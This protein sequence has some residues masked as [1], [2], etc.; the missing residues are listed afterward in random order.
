[1]SIED[2]YKGLE[3]SLDI[4]LS[5]RR[6]SELMKGGMAF[7]SQESLNESSLNTGLIRSQ[8]L[9]SAPDSYGVKN[10]VRHKFGKHGQ[11]QKSFG[12]H[13]DF[14]DIN[15]TDELRYGYSVTLFMDIIGSTK[16]GVIYTPEEVFGIKNDIIRCAI[17]TIDSFDGHVHR[18]MG[19]AVMAFFRSERKKADGLI[20]D[21]GI[22]ALN[23][24]AF[25]IEMMEKVVS[26]KLS[27]IGAEKIGIRIGI[28][29]GK[30]ED[31]I[32]GTYGYLGSHEVTATSYHVD[33]AAKLQQKAPKNSI[34]VGENFAELLGFDDDLL[35]VMEKNKN[36]IPEKKTFVTPNYITIDGKPKNYRQFL[37][38]HKS[39]N[40]YT[41]INSYPEHMELSATIKRSAKDPSD[42][43]YYRCS[44]SIK[45]GAGV[46][47]KVK[48]YDI[49]E[50]D[51]KFLFR[52]ENTGEEA[53][54]HDNNGNHECYVAAKYQGNGVYFASHWEDTKFK[55]I[56]HMFVS[57][58]SGNTRLMGEER[59]SIFITD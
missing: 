29:Y 17:E 23:C 22:D 26:P 5:K 36:G 40:T 10:I 15:G 27:D 59:F 25:L 47:F 18:I 30:D 3:R 1:M 49:H 2:I 14:E 46:S 45:K 41:P 11:L 35:K 34:L 43:E 32:W 57:V 42:D 13:P 4:T 55:G 38:D 16:L 44:R 54:G 33:V 52:V 12:C 28:D 50:R 39:Y 56:H 53:R 48:Y 7:D 21:S 31:V 9:A 19:D 8:S 20:M 51:L 6:H 37:V 58:W 24:S